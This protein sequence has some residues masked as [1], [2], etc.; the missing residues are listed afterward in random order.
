MAYPSRSSA[1]PVIV[2]TGFLGS[3]KT[4]LVNR[5]L[6]DRPRSAVVI[7]EFGAVPVDQ[8]LLAHHGAPLA[9]LSG[10]C[11]C[12]QVRASMAPLL[13]NL[14][15]AWREQSDRP[16]D[17]VLIETSGV[18]SPGP[19]L[20]TLLRDRWLTQRYRLQAVVTTVSAPDGVAQLEQFPE[21]QAQAALAD[22]L[23]ITHSEF[24]SPEALTR[25]EARLDRLALV[26]PRIVS[27]PADV[28]FAA[29]VS[30]RAAFSALRLSVQT[31]FEHSFR[32]V[33]LRLDAA[34][35][36]NPL[37]LILEQLLHQHA[38]RLVRVKGL[39]HTT[40][41]AAP[42]IV[43]GAAGRLY[44]PV[45][46]SAPIGEAMR[47]QLVFIATGSVDDLALAVIAAVG[48]GP[49]ASAGAVLH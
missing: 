26:T 43:Q 24:A 23:L 35:D 13:K 16:F 49:I 15:M 28:D 21:A 20:D 4:T 45:P 8:K 31:D 3:G 6:R 2:V 9:V 38:D 11:L 33:T 34:V 41:G 5:L 47:G 44:P 12:C 32:S 17:Q 7:N 1:L 30:S 48:A 14:W 27:H 18:A 39:A 42:I 10:G 37:R 19:V 36:W 25:L 29:L 40:G 46:V 22:A